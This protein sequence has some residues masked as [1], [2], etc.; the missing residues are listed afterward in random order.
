[1]QPLQ[2]S[3]DKGRLAGAHFARK[4]D[5]ALARLNTVHQSSKRLLNVFRE[6]KEPGIRVDIERVVF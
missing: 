5:E 3:V 1:M 4:R 2:E 6:E